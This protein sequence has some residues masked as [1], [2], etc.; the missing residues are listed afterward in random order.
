MRFARQTMINR[1]CQIKAQ[2]IPAVSAEHV[3]LDDCGPRHWQ[4][5]PSLVN[6]NS[7]LGIRIAKD[8][9]CEVL[10]W[11]EDK[12]PWRIN[13]VT[14]RP[15][16]APAGVLGAFWGPV[17]PHDYL[18]CCHAPNQCTSGA[19]L[20]SVRFN[21][22]FHI[23]SSRRKVPNDHTKRRCSRDDATIPD[24]NGPGA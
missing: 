9:I 4:K 20:S 13:L 2:L 8:K 6:S 11:T 19:A 10:N 12:M 22:D 15:D 16:Q 23:E 21:V 7:E 5:K 3:R 17:L 1:S 18:G 24:G 14:V